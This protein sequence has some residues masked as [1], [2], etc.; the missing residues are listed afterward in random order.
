MVKTR[1]TDGQHSWQ[2]TD[3][4]ESRVL[5]RGRVDGERH[6]RRRR[7]GGH[8]QANGGR[9][10]RRS[11][12]ARLTKENRRHRRTSAHFTQAPATRTTSRTHRVAAIVA[13]AFGFGGG[14][15]AKRDLDGQRRQRCR[16]RSRRLARRR[17]PWRHLACN[18]ASTTVSA[19]PQHLVWSLFKE[20]STSLP[21]DQSLFQTMADKRP[22]DDAVSF[23]P[24]TAEGPVA[25]APP[26]TT[27]R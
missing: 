19:Q 18:C 17:L 10:D 7:R 11:F 3:G 14:T 27:H 26:L 21:L 22:A 9:G 25:A 15:L 20:A 24:P 8:R 16:S 1:P 13:A 5:E 2:K 12:V 4:G 6:R 23:Y